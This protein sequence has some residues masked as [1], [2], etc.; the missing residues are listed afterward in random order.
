MCPAG[1][2]GAAPEVSWDFT[3]AL[4]QE[5]PRLAQQKAA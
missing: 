3:T 1:R 5:A 4:V 2:K